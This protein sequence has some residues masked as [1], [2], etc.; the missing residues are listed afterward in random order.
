MVRH[1]PFDTDQ[2]HIPL[3]DLLII[4]TV[5]S[6]GGNDDSCGLP[7]SDQIFQYPFF[8]CGIIKGQVNGNRVSP[9][10]AQLGDTCDYFGKQGASDIWDYD[11]YN[12]FF[13]QS[14][15]TGLL[16]RFYLIIRIPDGLQY[17]FREFGLNVARAIY[18]M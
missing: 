14:G 7:A 18:N 9:G 12:G 4:L 5:K 17:F 10:L 6:A 8:G 16:L 15:S 11:R 3:S 1:G 13:S 2:G